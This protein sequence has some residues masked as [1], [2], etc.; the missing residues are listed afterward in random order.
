MCFFEGMF[1]LAMIASR[2]LEALKRGRR[3]RT[4]DLQ[5]YREKERESRTRRREQSGQLPCGVT[6]WPPLP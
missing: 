1:F 4:I 3:R 2:D 6:P 5:K